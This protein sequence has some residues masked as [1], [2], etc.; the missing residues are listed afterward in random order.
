MSAHALDVGPLITNVYPLARIQEAFET[1]ASKP[2][3]FVKAVIQTNALG[4]GGK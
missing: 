2:E 3:T 1:A 4:D